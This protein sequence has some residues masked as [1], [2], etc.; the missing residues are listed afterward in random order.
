MADS[1]LPPLVRIGVDVGGTNTDA[2]ILDH[3]RAT[4]ADKGVLAWHKTATTSPHVTDGIETSVQNVLEQ[5]KV[6]PNQV[7]NLTI[8]TTHFIN[9]VV[10]HDAERISR[11]AVIRISKWYTR[12]IPPFS[13]FP[14]DLADI[15][16]GYYGYVDGGL[17]IDGSQECPV[18]RVQVVQRCDEIRERGISTIVINGV[19]SPIDAHFKQE[20]QV[21]KTVLQEMPC[22]DVVCASEVANLGFLERENAAILNASML[23][24]ARRT[25]QGF[26]TAMRRLRLECPLY[27][28][29]ND[30]TLIDATAAAR[31]P[32]RT[33]SSGATNSMRGASYLG[34]S[35]LTTGAIV[36]DIGG[37][38]SDV[39]VLL[40][41]GYPRQASAFTT[42]A[43]IRINYN[44]PHVESIGLGGGSILDYDNNGKVKIGPRSVGHRLTSMA[45]VFGGT[46]VT[47]TDIAMAHN[48]DVN[49]GKAGLVQDISL[50][51]ILQ[52]RNIIKTMLEQVIDRMK[53]S[54]DPLPVLLVGGGCA[55]APEELQGASVL[56]QP[57]FHQVAN[58]VGA[59]ISKVGS[60]IDI[61]QSTA[62]RTVSQAIDHARV[63][64]VENAVK[65]GAR[66]ESVTITDI[67]SIPLQYIE[68]QIRTIVRVAGDLSADIKTLHTL[69]DSTK[70][71]DEPASGRQRSDLPEGYNGTS[72]LVTLST[73]DAINSYRPRVVKNG[74]SGVLEWV[75]SETDL[76]WLADGCYVLGC[77]GGGTP[78]PEFLKLRD[79]VHAGH[80]IRII[81]AASLKNDAS[82]YCQSPSLPIRFQFANVPRGRQYGVPCSISRAS[83]W[84]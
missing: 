23:K 60:T 8:G 22:A 41:S 29:Q 38:T 33:F 48:P 62:D 75:L 63:L 35:E 49:I 66:Q 78:R 20:D 7:S 44:M 56:I 24:L 39:G 45:K 34:L 19:F 72:N 71:E 11:V 52:S 58:A 17:H 54:P 26:K 12:D 5:S 77:A 50:E 74:Q 59:A 10:E 43:G 25:I 14:P 31:F 1:N 15:M 47:A 4:L 2:V 81:E 70:V 6:P 51:V 68:H 9:A 76:I 55:I 83:I 18:N 30:G 57:P 65:A 73:I 61:I 82:I 36:V 53:T 42:V 84:G 80:K 46:T 21:R 79:Q 37:T 27:L 32:I 40:P 28:T 67:E 13:D 64:A 3:S 16:N 69:T